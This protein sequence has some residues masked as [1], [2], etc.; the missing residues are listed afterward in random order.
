ME[1][2]SVSTCW[3]FDLVGVV[4]RELRS[5]CCKTVELQGEEDEGRARDKGFI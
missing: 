4:E 3:R 1:R 5:R 2:D